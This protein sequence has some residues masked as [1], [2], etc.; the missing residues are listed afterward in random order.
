MASIFQMTTEERLEKLEKE[1]SHSKRRNHLLL[2]VVLLGAVAMTAGIG[3]REKVIEAT[4]FMLVDGNGKTRAFLA[5][6]E[7]G[8]KLGLLDENGNPRIGLIVDK[9]G[10]QL[11][12]RDENNKPRIGLF[13]SDFASGLTLIDENG[14]NRAGLVVDKEEG[15]GL[16]LFD[17]NGKRLW[18]A[19]P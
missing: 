19:P 15:P 16:G 8:P 13:L 14:K 18:K 9:D 5:M 11:I 4:G 17:E 7:G 2:A 3:S 10:P 1:L 12:L 6:G